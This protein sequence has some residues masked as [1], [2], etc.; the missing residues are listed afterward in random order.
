[1]K[2]FSEEETI[3]L[4][5]DLIKLKKEIDKWDMPLIKSEEGD[6]VCFADENDP[7]GAVVLCGKK[8]N[9]KI[10][11]Q[12]FGAYDSFKSPPPEWQPTE[13]QQKRMRDEPYIDLD[14]S[15]GGHIEEKSG[16]E[17][18][19]MRTKEKQKYFDEEPNIEINYEVCEE[20]GNNDC[21]K[22]HIK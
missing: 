9:I 18:L 6:Y 19:A 10:I 11:F 17:W 5:E 16:L 22:D 1:M 21:R 12:D 8:G 2:V 3:L 7:E 14:A 4:K 13:E 20:C 15:L